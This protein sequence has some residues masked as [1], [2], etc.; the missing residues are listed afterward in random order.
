MTMKAGDRVT[1]H[2]IPQHTCGGIACECRPT[3]FS[4]TVVA[5]VPINPEDQYDPNSLPILVLDVD[6][7]DDDLLPEER[8]V[9]IHGLPT[10][11]SRVHK[12]GFMTRQSHAPRAREAAAPDSGSWTL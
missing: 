10:V 2:L 3:A 9:V 6:F 8:D 7:V 4:A 5:E 12:L 11:R 1:Y